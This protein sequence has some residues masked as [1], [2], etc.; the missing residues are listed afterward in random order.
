MSLFL[1]VVIV[2]VA[3]GLFFFYLQALC[4]KILARKLE[5]KFFL[6]VVNANNLE[7]SS[8][9][10]AIEE[11]DAPMDCAW[12]SKM[13]KCDFIAL[14]Y[15]LKNAVN[16]NQRYSPEERLL[17]LYSRLMFLS[18]V[19]HHRLRLQEKA[20]IL[21]LTTILQYFANVVG[22]RINIVR[23]GNLT[24]SDFLVNI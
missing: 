19:I 22:Q 5:Q 15:L 21:E 13:L 3:T 10:K 11:S 18:L 6:S 2:I 1:A 17:I 12:L 16:I 9:R 4:Q 24:T 8:V 20:A 14:T 23:F 7:F